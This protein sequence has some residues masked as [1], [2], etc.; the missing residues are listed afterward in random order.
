[1]PSYDDVA[2]VTVHD[3]GDTVKVYFTSGF[4]SV[5]TDDGHMTTFYIAQFHF[6]APAEHTIDG[7]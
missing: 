5:W 4:L 1:M 2:N 7:A 3:L 6:H